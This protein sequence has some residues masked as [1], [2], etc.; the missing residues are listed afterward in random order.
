MCLFTL[1]EKKLNKDVVRIRPEAS[2]DA[3]K[4]DTAKF[5]FYDHF[6]KN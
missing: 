6:R 3:S 2:G 5:F 4:R 1:L